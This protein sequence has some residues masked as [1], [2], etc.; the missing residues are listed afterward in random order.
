MYYKSVTFNMPIPIHNHLKTL[1]GNKN[2]SKFV[3]IAV[4]EK[5]H[6]LEENLK[7]AYIDASKDKA[8][9]KEINEWENTEMEGW[10]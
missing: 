9:N 2:M 10:S 7:K 1:V 8:R 3:A 4:A 5:L 6:E